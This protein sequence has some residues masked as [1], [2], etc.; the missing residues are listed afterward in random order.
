MAKKKSPTPA[1][2]RSSKDKVE[3]ARKSRV[4][5][6]ELNVDEN[7]DAD[8]ATDLDDVDDDDSDDEDEDDEDDDQ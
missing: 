6:E 5:D 4:V 7:D 1:P 2:E 3:P 8:E